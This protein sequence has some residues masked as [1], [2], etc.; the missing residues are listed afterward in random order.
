MNGLV[1]SIL[2]CP[3][4]KLI[5]TERSSDISTMRGVLQEVTGNKKLQK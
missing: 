5:S 1:V 3:I 2:V 4:L